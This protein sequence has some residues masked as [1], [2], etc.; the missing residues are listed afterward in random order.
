M[1]MF[2][3]H[4]NVHHMLADWAW[5]GRFDAVPA[6]SLFQFYILTVH[7]APDARD[8]VIEWPDSQLIVADR[9][10]GLQRQPVGQFK[11]VSPG[12]GPPGKKMSLPFH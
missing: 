7:Q 5:L 9:E 6:Q 4:D 12:D 2:I 3:R 1:V 8:N 11:S 10:S